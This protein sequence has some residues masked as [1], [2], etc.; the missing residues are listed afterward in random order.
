[1]ARRRI[2]VRVLRFTFASVA[3]LTAF[4]GPG[5]RARALPSYAQKEGKLC[6][7]CHIN[8]EGSGNRNAV[9]KQY[10]LNGHTFKRKQP[11]GAIGFPERTR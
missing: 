3:L 7:Y 4:A 11:S 9:G 5:E 1:M 2:L 6:T 10:E 8:P